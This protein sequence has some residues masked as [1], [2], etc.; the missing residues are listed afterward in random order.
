MKL[1]REICKNDRKRQTMTAVVSPDR[2]P[3]VVSP[4]VAVLPSPHSIDSPPLIA[5]GSSLLL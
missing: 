3:L 1:V 4:A 2:D 5:V